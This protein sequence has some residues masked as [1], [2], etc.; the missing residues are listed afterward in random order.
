MQ[1]KKIFSDRFFMSV[2]PQPD[3]S[4]RIIKSTVDWS[5]AGIPLA[6]FLA[7]RFT[8]RTIDEWRS[9]IGAGEIT[10]NGKKADG[11]YV[12]MMHDVIEYRPT[13]I[14][15]PA[16]SLDYKVVYEDDS[17]LVV[18][19]PGNLC[20]HPS[21]PFYKNTLWYLLCS[22]YGKI[23]LLS[24]LD[25]E[26]SGLL[27]A[28]K[29]PATAAIMNKNR[30][31]AKSYLAAVHGDFSDETLTASG[32]LFSDPHSAVRKKRRFAAEAPDGALR[33]ESAET[34]I[35]LRQRANGLSLLEC[36]PVTGRM[37]QIRC[38]L[39]SL[40]YPVVGDKLYGLDESLFL[41]VRHD[42]FT[43]QDLETLMISRQALHSYRLEFLHPH[44]ENKIVTAES[45]APAEIEK[46]FAPRG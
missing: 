40:G 2:T 37:H 44:D 12:L 15:E 43:P 38:T 6:V 21:G 30:H 42:E 20:V 46:L 41:K 35:S 14:V 13:D 24:R 34:K 31:I 18:D 36:I 28:A 5:G 8:Y 11:N 27:V 10:V 23:H 26:T 17:L 33:L 4:Q 16:A 1:E 19:K 9:R 39:F 25:R 7:G 22:K 3:I 32:W 45:E 29:N